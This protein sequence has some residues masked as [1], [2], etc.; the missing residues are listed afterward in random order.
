MY[1]KHHAHFFCEHDEIAEESMF[2]F[3]KNLNQSFPYITKM[4][5]QQADYVYT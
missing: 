4:T 1:L 3:H 2:P 5:V